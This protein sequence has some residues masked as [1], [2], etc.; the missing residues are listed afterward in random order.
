M[1]ISPKTTLRD[2]L[3]AHPQAR[4]VLGWYGIE[5]IEDMDDKLRDLCESWDID[6]EDLEAD[7]LS[8]CS[9]EEEEKEEEDEWEES[10]ADDD[11]D[12]DD[13]YSD[14]EYEDLDEEEAD[15]PMDDEE[16]I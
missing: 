4:D 9:D 10:Y 7:L 3:E 11:E 6:Y 2:L 16:G 13:E 14:G 15:E 5:D 12:D 8:Y 1:Q